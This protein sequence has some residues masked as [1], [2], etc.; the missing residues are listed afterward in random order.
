MLL[1]P[2]LFKYEDII[3]N[4]NMHSRLTFGYN[5]FRETIQDIICFVSRM[6]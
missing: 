1:F 3:S 4:K 6:Q 2:Q 5:K